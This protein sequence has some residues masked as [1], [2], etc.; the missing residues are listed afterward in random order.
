M[1][2]DKKDLLLYAVTDRSWLNGG[3]AV[4]TGGRSAKRRRYLHPAYG[5]RN[6]MKSISWRK[7]RNLRNCAGDI[8]FRSSSMTMW[9]SRQPA[10]QMACM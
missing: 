3:D 9:R 10:A 1:K 5:K 6:W 4:Q 8:E 7:Q 2:C